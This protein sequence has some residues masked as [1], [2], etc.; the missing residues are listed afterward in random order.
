MVDDP[1][2]SVP[3]LGIII[4][5]DLVV[6]THVQRTISRRMAELSQLRQIRRLVL[7]ATLPTLM[8]TLVPSRMLTGL[9]AY[10]LRR[11]KSVL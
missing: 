7:P 3:D 11:L 1:T 9:S 8:V 6:K 5:A 4:D 10:L 2:T